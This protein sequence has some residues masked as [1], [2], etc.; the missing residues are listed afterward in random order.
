VNAG[1]A[2]IRASG[3][4]NIAAVRVLNAG[5]IQVGGKSSGVPTVAAPNVAS[6]SAA[7]STV[8]AGAN[9]AN[10]VAR[11]QQQNPA[12]QEAIPLPSIITVEVLGYGDD[13]S[14]A[15]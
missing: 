7:S 4:L 9:A 8:G 6:L 13:G 10:E 5:N 1:D 14:V 2:G 11:Q 15:D 3:N 12:Q